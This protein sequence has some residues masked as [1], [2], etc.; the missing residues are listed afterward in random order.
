M[1]SLILV[2]ELCV[3]SLFTGYYGDQENSLFS[4]FTSMIAHAEGAGL[5]ISINSTEELV[6][7]SRNYNSSHKNDI[8]KITVSDTATTGG[9]SNFKKMGTSSEDAF[10][11]TIILAGA[12]ITLNLPTAMFGYVTDDVS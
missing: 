6:T 3:G 9:L 8:I 12:S 4:S 10:D 11:G 7:Y 2:I 1:I 5:P